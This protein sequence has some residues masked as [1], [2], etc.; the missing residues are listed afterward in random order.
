MNRKSLAGKIGEKIAAVYLIKRGYAVLGRNYREKFGEIDLIVRSPNGTLVFCEVK[1]LLTN[2]MFSSN[3]APEDNAN[4]Q[5]R[6]KMRRVANFFAAKNSDLVFEERGWRIDLV[7]I[8]LEEASGRQIEEAPG[9]Q[10]AKQ[11]SI[12]VLIRKITHYENVA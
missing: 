4:H 5:K 2:K 9:K 10:P 1:T 8:T 12:K 7:A 11:N 3:F 6:I